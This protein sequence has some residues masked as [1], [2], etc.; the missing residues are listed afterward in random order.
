LTHKDEETRPKSPV[1]VPV[2]LGKPQIKGCH[3]DHTHIV[4]QKSPYHCRDYNPGK[5]IRKKE[6]GLINFGK[7]FTAEFADYKGQDYGKHN[8]ADYHN[9]IVKKGIP[10]DDPDIGV[11]EQE[12]EILKSHPSAPNNAVN[13]TARYAVI[14]ERY[15]DAEHGHITEQEIPHCCRYDQQGVF[16]II[17]GPDFFL[18]HAIKRNAI[19]FE[20][21]LFSLEF[22]VLIKI[23]AADRRPGFAAAIIY[24]LCNQYIFHKIC[25][26]GI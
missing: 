24:G 15:N 23:F 2:M 1:G 13:K 10:D 21:K 9:R 5:E 7:P 14:L 12:F 18:Y 4:T 16:G 6:Y 17:F 20:I 26:Q 8:A 11:A 22:F 19:F 3:V 25:L